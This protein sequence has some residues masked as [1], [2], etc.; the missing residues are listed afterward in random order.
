MEESAPGQFNFINSQLR[1]NEN[2][3]ENQNEYEKMSSMVKNLVSC[4]IK[5][6]FKDIDHTKEDLK[7]RIAFA[8]EAHENVS[9]LP[10]HNL[11]DEND[12]TKG[13]ASGM[14]NGT[15]GTNS[16][17]ELEKALAKA[18]ARIE[19]LENAPSNKSVPEAVA[20]SSTNGTIGTNSNSEL[21][22]A[23]ARIEE[24]EKALSDK[25]VPAA[26]INSST[27][28]TINN[29]N[30]NNSNNNNNNNG[31]NTDNINQQPKSNNSKNKFT[32]FVIGHYTPE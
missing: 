7:T 5:N 11:T 20:N 24:L 16:N 18:L 15:I 9:I 6:I 1:M 19:E 21:A 29:N 8:I 30:N 10:I 25:S 13:R 3:V 17:S 32:N 27:N 14:A 26:D 31:T 12:L 22:K 2:H 28:G 23:L 4:K